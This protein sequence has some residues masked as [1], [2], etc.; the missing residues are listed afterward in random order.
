MRRLKQFTD[1]SHWPR[2]KLEHD[3]W[4]MFRFIRFNTRGERAVAGHIITC[5]KAAL[6]ALL[7][8]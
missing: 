8:G 2:E 4:Y 3:D 5:S 1:L 6:S 7:K